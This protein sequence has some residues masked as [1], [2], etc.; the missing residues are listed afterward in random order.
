MNKSGRFKLYMAVGLL[1][2]LVIQTVLLLIFKGR[3]KKK[4]ISGR[5]VDERGVYSWCNEY[6]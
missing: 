4:T 2:L 1:I 6:G 3:G 5:Q